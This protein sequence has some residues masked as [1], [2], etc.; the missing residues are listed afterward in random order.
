M[1]EGAGSVPWGDRSPAT[2]SVRVQ[3]R[4][5][6]SASRPQ[7][8]HADLLWTL[9]LMVAGRP[10]LVETGPLQA[11]AGARRY[12]TLPSVT[13]PRMLLPVDTSA[14]LAASL[15]G[16]NGLR[17]LQ[18][19]AGRAVLQRL[20]TLPPVYRAAGDHLVLDTFDETSAELPPLWV[21]LSELFREPVLLATSVH[22]RAPHRKPLFQVITRSGR[23]VGYAKLGWNERTT[24]AVDVEASALE[25]LGEQPPAGVI[26][27]ALL[28][29][30]PWGPHKLLVTAPLPTATRRYTGR[31][32]PP[33]V[34]ALRAVAAAGRMRTQRLGDASYVAGLR[35]RIGQQQSSGVAAHVPVTP[36]LT[37]L[38]QLVD[39]EAD[40]E[41][42]TGGW[43][44]DW[45]PWNLAQHGDSVLAWDWE[46]AARDVPVGFDCL[47]YYFEVEANVRG[48]GAD[49]AFAT[50]SARAAH[51]LAELGLS[52]SA[53]DVV[54]TLY[55]A[56]YFTRRVGNY[57]AGGP[58]HVEFLDGL[59]RLITARC[60]PR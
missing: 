3:P 53:R 8:V 46:Y 43:H 22:R 38:D 56:E 32:P 35:A 60:D 29:H 41:L 7:A 54:E 12:V 28:H 1:T 40:L 10:L 59:R 24:Q 44:G 45:V 39:R 57:A 31:T 48:R 15:V 11:A 51:P 58:A 52:A 33:P 26:V 13:R 20:L 27:P 18:R 42:E 50:A 37:A 23:T 6:S 5:T 19:R 14:A 2:A 55:L 47:H 21:L 36:V 4:R 16:D 17:S 25:R 34:S 30:A 9:G 49:R